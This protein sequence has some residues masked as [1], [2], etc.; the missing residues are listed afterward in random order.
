GIK[1]EIY[2]VDP[3]TGDRLNKKPDHV[4]TTDENG[5]WGPFTAKPDARYEFFA[6]EA[7]ESGRPQHTYRG[8]FRHSTHLMYLK[9]LPTL[10]S[11]AA[12]IISGHIMYTDEQTGLIVQNNSRAMISK[13]DPAGHGSDSL[14]I[15]GSEVLSADVAPEKLQLVALFAFDNMQA[16]GS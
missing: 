4:Y 12:N 14:T 11:Y 7:G 13:A 3:D 5:A 15:E 16:Q 9:A 1:L 10:G 6:P 8:P 2:E